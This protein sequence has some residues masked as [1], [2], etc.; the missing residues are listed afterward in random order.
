M[1]AY[2]FWRCTPCQ[3]IQVLNIFFNSIAS[4][5]PF[6]WCK[7]AFWFDAAFCNF[8][9]LYPVLWDVYK[10]KQNKA[11]PPNLPHLLSH[12]EFSELHALHL[13]LYWS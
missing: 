1:K 13:C 6:F 7:V 12:I 9:Y 11:S 2:T 5:S 8:A 4:D 3:K 10:N